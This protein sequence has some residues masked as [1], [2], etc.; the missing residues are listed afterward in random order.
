MHKSDRE[1]TLTLFATAEFSLGDYVLLS[2]QHINLEVGED[3][4]LKLCPWF[5]GPF[6][7][8]SII[9]GGLQAQIAFPYEVPP[10]FLHQP[11]TVSR[12]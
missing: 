9:P 5:I 11:F 1:S 3:S 10:R 2:T 8:V 7:I 4:T 6:Q 12:H